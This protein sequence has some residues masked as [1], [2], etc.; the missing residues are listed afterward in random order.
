MMSDRARGAI[1][2]TVETYGR[3]PSQDSTGSRS[4]QDGAWRAGDEPLR[5]CPILV[6][7]MYL[8]EYTLRPIGATAS[9]PCMQRRAGTVQG[10]WVYLRTSTNLVAAVPL[11][12]RGNWRAAQS[13]L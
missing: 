2:S 11:A 6:R 8:Y 3:R 5:K 7:D 12:R 10:P 13:R 1:R 9:H 4:W